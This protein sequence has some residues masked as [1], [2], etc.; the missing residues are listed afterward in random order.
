[1]AGQAHRLLEELGLIRDRAGEMGPDHPRFKRWH[2]EVKSFFRRQ[3]DEVSLR[4]FE[5]LSFARG[6]GAMW[7]RGDLSPQEVR[8]FRGDLET[9]RAVLERAPDG[10]AADAPSCSPRRG[11][12][13]DMET[14]QEAGERKNLLNP[15]GR[16]QAIDRLLAQLEAELKRPDATVESAQGV[17][18]ELLTYKRVA[19][20]LDRLRSEAAKA[21]ARW[22]PVREVMA[23][24]WAVR[25]ELLVDLLPSLLRG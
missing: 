15:E 2:L 13:K 16:N 3:G 10:P 12:G 7:K 8:R 19:G 5:H 6:N 4:R 14:T 17:M 9:A 11:G 25:K 1:M 22:E 20:L 23:E 18:N 24:L 21:D